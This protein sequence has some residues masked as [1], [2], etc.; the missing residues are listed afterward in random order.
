MGPNR[1]TGA[2][3]GIVEAFEQI[4][5]LIIE[6]EADMEKAKGGNKAAGTRVRQAM[7]DIKKAA[8]DVREGI[9]TIRDGTPP[10]KPSSK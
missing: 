5:K 3:G 1:A 9:L 4:K 8:Q 10:A 7:Q 6:A 2:E